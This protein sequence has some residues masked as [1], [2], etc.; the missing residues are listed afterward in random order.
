M[1]ARP[2]Q[3]ACEGHDTVAAVTAELNTPQ[4]NKPDDENRIL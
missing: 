2:L 3:V 1:P 4:S